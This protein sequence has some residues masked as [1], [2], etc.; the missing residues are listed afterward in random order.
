MENEPTEGNLL[1]KNIITCIVRI[2]II[3]ELFGLELV[4]KLIEHFQHRHLLRCHQRHASRDQL[5]GRPSPIK[6]EYNSIVDVKKVP[7]IDLLYGNFEEIRLKPLMR[8]KK[9][10]KS[11]LFDSLIK[12][13]H[14]FLSCMQ[15][16]KRWKNKACIGVKFSTMDKIRK[17]C[18]VAQLFE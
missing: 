16:Q 3:E 9:S 11:H 10:L 14:S 17:A 4:M 18:I 13:T 1:T 8:R 5:S 7:S 15:V 12:D 2:I 6:G